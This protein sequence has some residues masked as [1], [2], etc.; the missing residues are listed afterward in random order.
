MAADVTLTDTNIHHVFRDS[1]VELRV[2]IGDG[3]PG[4][5]AVTWRGELVP[6]DE[7]RQCW[8]FGG[9]GRLPNTIA[10]VVTIVQDLNPHSN[11]TSV[12]YTLTGGVAEEDFPYEIDVRADKGKANYVI[13][14]VFI[15][16]LQDG[17]NDDE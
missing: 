16:P 3:Q 6:F 2:D 5:S 9:D 14:F 7:D 4:G 15:Q 10:R 13:T 11:H 8:R 12:T 17:E 1:I